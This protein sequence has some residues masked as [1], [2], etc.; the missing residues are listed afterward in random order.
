[1]RCYFDGSLDLRKGE[2]VKITN[3]HKEPYGDYELRVHILEVTRTGRVCRSWFSIKALPEPIEGRVVSSEVRGD[4]STD[5]TTCFEIEE[6]VY[7]NYV[8]VKA[9]EVKKAQLH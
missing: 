4:L 5:P 1:M 6:G 3:A 7:D 9:G 2:V 8:F